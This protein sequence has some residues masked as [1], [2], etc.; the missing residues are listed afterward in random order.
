VKLCVTCADEMVQPGRTQCDR[1]QQ[2][3]P[4]AHKDFGWDQP[5][6]PRMADDLTP[7]LLELLD[8]IAEHT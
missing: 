7:T 2:Q 3:D 5:G 4:Y 1:C 6:A 8:K